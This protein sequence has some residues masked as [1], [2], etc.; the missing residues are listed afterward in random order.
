MGIVIPKTGRNCTFF[1]AHF[2][3]LLI[4]RALRP[5]RLK[6]YRK[7]RKA[8]KNKQGA[9]FARRKRPICPRLQYTLLA[10]G[11]T[12]SGL[13]RG[14]TVWTTLSNFYLPPRP[15]GSTY[16]LREAGGIGF[17]STVKLKTFLFPAETSAASPEASGSR[18]FAL[19]GADSAN[20]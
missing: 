3:S 20:M 19:T 4:F 12:Y 8:L 1:F 6:F 15:C 5:L 14:T 18:N 17:G 7:V 2:A 10:R 9:E 11:A 13:R 16:S